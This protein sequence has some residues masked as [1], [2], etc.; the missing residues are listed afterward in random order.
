MKTSCLIIQIFVFIKDDSSQVLLYITLVENFKYINWIPDR[1]STIWATPLSS[2]QSE[3][4]RINIQ[5][6]SERSSTQHA[7]L[8]LSMTNSGRLTNIVFRGQYNYIF[9]PELYCECVMHQKVYLLTQITKMN[10]RGLH[11][12]LSGLH[13]SLSIYLCICVFNSTWSVPPNPFRSGDRD[14]LSLSLYW[15]CTVYISPEK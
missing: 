14:R 1:L 11:L 13:P 4:G 12:K 7:M 10:K 6:G 5:T 3:K 2:R 15:D 8:R 9:N